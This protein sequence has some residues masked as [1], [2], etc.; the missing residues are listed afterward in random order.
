MIKKYLIIEVKQNGE[1]RL[2]T[3]ALTAR[4]AFQIKLDLAKRF[5]DS[6]IVI[7][8]EKRP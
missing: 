1:R 4:G 8:K 6:L 5:S 3:K 2:L 7:E